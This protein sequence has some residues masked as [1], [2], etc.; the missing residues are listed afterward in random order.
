MTITIITI[1]CIAVLAIALEEVIHLNK[2]KSTL[3]LGCI[4]W[5]LMYIFAD[6]ETEALQHA[7]EENLLE[8]A[9]LWL[10][11]M[12][13]MTFV[14]YLN[15]HGL[16]S[17]LILKVV[18]GQ[19]SIRRLTVFI[20]IFAILLSMLC[21][22]ITATLVS[23]GVI[24]SFQLKRQET[25]RLCVLTVFAVN[26]GGVILITGDVTTLMIFN[27]GHLTISNLL[28]LF[29]PAIIGVLALTVMFLCHKNRDVHA[30]YR[31]GIIHR[32]DIVIG[33]LFFATIIA[34]MAF[35]VLFNI[36][37]VLT[38][39]SGLS[40]MFLIGSLVNR[41]HHEVHLLEYIRKIQFDTL[42]FFLGILL[43]VGALQQ[44][45][46]L[47]W[48]TQLYLSMSPE[49]SNAM[50]GVMSSLLDNVPLTAAILKSQPELTTTQ[51][52]SLAYAVGVGGSILVIGSAAGIVAM[53]KV[54]EMTFLSY[55]RYSPHLLIAY[56]V[57]Y[58]F[59]LFV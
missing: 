51:W 8:I 15:A 59:A 58:G 49:V 40:V 50:I 36:P 42:L 6:Q 7:L 30:E 1:A 55:L 41:F 39:L 34:T 52:L 45:G 27:E 18:P 26:S 4:S 3:F 11:L 44:Q 12:A 53:S 29:Y 54:E 24:Q 5:I 25:I 56:S 14:A 38:F 43:L 32:L 33:I 20:C 13:T 48:L 17:T 21:D 57:G 10:F 22:N 35:T 46:V 23:I 47:T 19:L 9:E 2:A 28:K 16:I 31:L 37:P